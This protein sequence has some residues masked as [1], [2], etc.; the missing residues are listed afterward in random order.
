MSNN[1]DDFDGPTNEEPDFGRG[2]DDGFSAGSSA[3]SSEDREA[4][5]G[6]TGATQEEA[7][8]EEHS[9][10]SAAEPTQEGPIP[11]APL[12]IGGP[13]ADFVDVEAKVRPETDYQRVMAA[14]KAD[15]ARTS[16]SGDY[17]YNLGPMEELCKQFNEIIKNTGGNQGVIE[18]FQHHMLNAFHTAAFE[19]SAALFKEDGTPRNTKTAEG[20]KARA[21]TLNDAAEIFRSSTK[22]L[23]K[24][25]SAAG[26]DAKSLAL[27]VE[28]N[29]SV[30][31]KQMQDMLDRGTSKLT[32]GEALLLKVQDSFGKV[33]ANGDLAGDARQHNNQTIAEKLRQ[34]KEVSTDIRINAGKPQWESGDGKAAQGL[35][36]SLLRELNEITEGRETKLNHRSLKKKLDEVATDL[37]EAS[38]LTNDK[39]F[40]EDLRKMAQRINDLVE[41]ITNAI[42]AAF[43]RFDSPRPA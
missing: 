26:Y 4:T 1:Y 7:R 41:R 40:Q 33:F 29:M 9:T 6:R 18:A 12:G 11:S 24:D 3:G 22:E 27:T 43:S 15:A 39:D 10:N 2:G 35:A 23:V 21:D 13:Y 17:I 37:T 14:L 32:V 34:L 28:K 20:L 42:R 36:K 25:L 38:S 30:R 19:H 8:G 16:E 31:L 5:S